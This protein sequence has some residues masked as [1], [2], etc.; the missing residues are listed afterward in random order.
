MVSPNT[1]ETPGGAAS[2]GAP[3]SI[4]DVVIRLAGNSQDGYVKRID[5]VFTR[6]LVA[7]STARFAR[8]APGSDAP[9]DHIGLIAELADSRP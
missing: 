8:T 2:A 3:R 4:H 5:Y 7:V 1:P 9:S 6:G